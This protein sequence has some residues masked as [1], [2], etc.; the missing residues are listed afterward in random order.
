MMGY[1]T[2][3]YVVMWLRFVLAAEVTLP[4]SQLISRPHVAASSSQ[5]LIHDPRW[6]C[7]PENSSKPSIPR[8][9]DS[10]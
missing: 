2:V 5:S 7:L 4:C 1:G 10:V 6:Q 3:M 8:Q 9:C